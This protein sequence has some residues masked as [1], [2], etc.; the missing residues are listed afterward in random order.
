YYLWTHSAAFR[1]FFI[2]VWHDIMVGVVAVRDFFVKDI[3]AA[4]DWLWDHTK[5]IFLAVDNWL[6]DRWQHILNNVKVVLSFFTDDIPAGWNRLVGI[7]R[8]VFDTVRGWIVTHFNNALAFVSSIP[9]RVLGFF[10][11]LPGQFWSI[12]RNI[13][14]SLINGAGSLLSRLGTFFLNLL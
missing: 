9:G 8:D 13:I 1:N 3:P 14:D 11:S 2:A 12:G 10:T 4:W 6:Y 5:A 7:A